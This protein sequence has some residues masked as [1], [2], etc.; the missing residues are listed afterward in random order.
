MRREFWVTIFIVVFLFAPVF[1][2]A[3]VVI[4]EICPTGCASTEHQ[5]VEIFNPESSAIDLTGWKFWENST[6]HGLSISSSSLK[7]SFS[8]EPNEYAVITQDDEMFC[9]DH[10]GFSSA[11]F[12]SVWG[13]LKDDGEEVGLKD[14]NDNFIEQF[15]YPAVISFSMQRKD[16][17]VLANE[18][19]NWC[20]HES[21]NTVGAVSVCPTVV[22]T[23]TTTPTSTLPVETPT[24]TPTSTTQNTNNI[25]QLRINELVPNPNSGEDG[26][27]GSP[28]EWIEIY[29]TAT[30][31]VV[32]DGLKI[33]DAVGE[34]ATPTGT[35]EA[36]GFFVV[37][38]TSS[39]L[40]NTGGDSVIL[41]D[42][43]DTVID[44]AYYN[45]VGK[46]YSIARSIDGAGSFTETT[47]LTRGLANVIVAPVVVVPSNGGGGG[48]GGS[49]NN[50][51][52][53]PPVI[54]TPDIVINELVSDPTDGAVEFVEL[55]NKSNASVSLAGWWIEEGGGSRNVLSGSILS[56]G[57]FVLEKPS[58]SLNNAGDIVRLMSAD[59]KEI[60]KV[61]Y[62]NWNDGSASNN[63]VFAS[64]P[65]S[66][67]RKTDGYDTNNDHS[68]F[69]VT[70]QIT[71][72]GPNIIVSSIAGSSTA[73]TTVSTTLQTASEIAE[74]TLPMISILLPEEII[75]GEPVEFDASETI[76]LEEDELSFAWDFGDG[77]HAYGETVL[78]EYKED[79]TFTISLTV[80]DVVGQS[81]ETAKV[82]ITNS[83]LQ[84]PN[85]DEPVVVAK[86]SVKT[87]ASVAKG[88]YLGLVGLDKMGEV[89]TG[90]RVKVSGTVAVLPNIF[91]SQYFYISGST[92]SPQ[93]G[94]QIYMN[95][96]KFPEL[97]IGD[98]VEVSG[99]ISEPYGEKRVKVKNTTDIRIIKNQGEPAPAELTTIDLSET[100]GALVKIKG[101][102]TE[103]KSTY[104]FIDDG[105]GE[106]KVAFKR[107]AN[108]TKGGLQ[109]GDLVE[110]IGIVGQSSSGIQLL[111]RKMMDIVKTG[112]IEE[113][114]LAGSAQADKDKTT[115]TYLT[116]TA[117]GLTSILISLAAKA[118][119]KVAGGLLKRVG[120]LAMLVVRRKTKG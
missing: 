29:N 63:A 35:I 7:Q 87:N 113:D 2:S 30:S 9:A 110:I 17:S 106:V 10:P 28:Q 79:G 89:G 75:V 114:L 49:S 65:F 52:A 101:E 43:S 72:G 61:V 27:A 74:N 3:N 90:D 62:G 4:N 47:S 68:N 41:K 112:H 76:D 50:F 104:L 23:P 59:G 33:F 102:G 120:G 111:P 108:I 71:K 44:S 105:E 115:E 73:S 116:A 1:V 37:E 96:K 99:E 22:E 20:E 18:P 55:Y 16:T 14:N 51:V 64:D 66:L 95:S 118:R 94:V 13:T 58:G 31:S 60:D 103:M 11:I 42:V 83:K 32:I 93:A 98:V 12:D 69:V 67:V 46:G 97:K 15:T 8:L 77:S 39:K 92:S 19:T 91:G 86:T 57:F 25:T 24:T 82:K 117:G 78:H 70:A 36:G 6:R 80:K 40:N 100:V 5:W 45:E 81:K 84:I 88:S 38:L 53:P 107:G 21:G 85:G 34:I 119:G 109:I 48:G 56:L 54:L 26:S